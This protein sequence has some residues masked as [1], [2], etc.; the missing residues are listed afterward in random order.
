M[1]PKKLSRPLSFC[2]IPSLAGGRVPSHFSKV[3]LGGAVKTPFLDHLDCRV[4]KHQT[5]YQ[6]PPHDQTLVG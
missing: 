1:F 3:F 4:S 2:R 6:S 5:D